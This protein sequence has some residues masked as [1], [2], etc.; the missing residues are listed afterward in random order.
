MT[1]GL[2]ARLVCAR[3]STPVDPEQM[4]GTLD[5][6]SAET[7]PGILLTMSTFSSLEVT[8]ASRTDLSGRL[9]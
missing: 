8:H 7:A 4:S 6:P 9:H 5:A 3:L 1:S 2:P